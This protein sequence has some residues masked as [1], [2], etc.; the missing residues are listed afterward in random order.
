MKVLFIISLIFISSTS[1]AQEYNQV[2]GK[3]R[4]QGE[5]RKK[6]EDFNQ[7]MYVGQFKDDKPV[8]LFIY[9]YTNSK[10]KAKVDH[11]DG[12]GRAVAVF[13]HENGHKM[14]VGIYRDMKKDSIW[15]N[16]GPSGR[17]STKETFKNDVLHGQTVVFFVPEELED[18]STRISEIFLYDNGKLE[19]E[20]TKYFENG[21]VHMKGQYVNG[22]KDGLWTEY[23]LNGNRA[24]VYSYKNGLQHGWQ[25]AFDNKNNRIG[26]TYYYMGSVLSGKELEDY[27]KL[28]EEN[29]G[30]ND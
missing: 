28:L 22:A 3:G 15:T 19:G 4:K 25:V 12:S 6:Y 9:Y 2:D 14:S 11:G 13:Y 8:G 18:K 24:A 29:G 26:K 16:Y 10:V 21:N 5:W 1:F 30:G 20:Y 27:L 23:H 17:L 7:Y